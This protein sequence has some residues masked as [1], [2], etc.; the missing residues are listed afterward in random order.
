MHFNALKR[1]TVFKSEKVEA[2]REWIQ[3]HAS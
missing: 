1:I 2:A 3:I